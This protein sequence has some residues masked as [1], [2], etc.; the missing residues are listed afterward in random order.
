MKMLLPS[1]LALTIACGGSPEPT[2]RVVPI[3]QGTPAAEAAPE[4]E[5]KPEAKAKW[6]CPMCAG[7][8]SDQPGDCPT[9]GMPLVRPEDAAAV[10][11]EAYHA[12]HGHEGHDHG[13]DH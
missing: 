9:C 13:H 8:E 12:E 11:A 4:V 3:Q 1:L 10:D 6:V 7:V 5:A 2:T